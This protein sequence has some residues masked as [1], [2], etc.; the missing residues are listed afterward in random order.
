MPSLF[1]PGNANA[2]LI[3]D[4]KNVGVRFT[5]RPGKRATVR[6]RAFELL[7]G[8]W[9]RKTFWGLRHVCFEL[10]AG[11]SLGILGSNGAGKSTL[12]K[13]LAGIMLPDEGG[14][15]VEG[16]IAPLLSLNAGLNRQLSGRDN[17]RLCGALSGLTDS[18]IQS[19]L[20]D[21]V[22]FSELGEAIDHP[23]RTY[24]NGMRTRLAFSIATSIEPDLL[25]VDEVLGVG[26]AYFKKKSTNR[27]LDLMDRSRAMIVVSHSAATIRRL[28][29]RALWLEG[30][31]PLAMG[32]VESVAAEYQSWQRARGNATTENAPKLRIAA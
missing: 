25:I 18:E 3:V 4:A 28:C 17:V 10:R 11:E 16:R 1:D 5:V 29:D 26:D 6:S 14:L 24:S 7:A 9:G 8:Q 32:P 30:G 2:E 27:M 12:C 13:L 22:A 31:T 19:L 23:V 20:P 15:S 21:I